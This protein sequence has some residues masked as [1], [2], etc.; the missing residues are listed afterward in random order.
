MER[1]T[2]VASDIQASDPCELLNS[3][4]QDFTLRPYFDW[5][6]LG[7]ACLIGLLLHYVSFR[8]PW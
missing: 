4:S 8:I 3:P 2:I 5:I 7:I 6:C 1:E